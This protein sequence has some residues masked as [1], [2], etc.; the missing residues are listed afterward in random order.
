MR[1]PSNIL[2]YSSIFFDLQHIYRR[3]KKDKRERIRKQKKQLFFDLPHSPWSLMGVTAPF[4][5]QST[6]SGRSS[7][8]TFA[9]LNPVV[10]GPLFPAGLKPVRAALNSSSVRSANWLASSQNLWFP[11]LTD[12]MNATLALK[13]SY[14]RAFSAASLYTRPYLAIHCSCLSTMDWAARSRA[15]RAWIAQAPARTA[16]IRR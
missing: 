9:Y 14:R 12:S 6:E 11:A 3:L 15:A 4:A 16:K 13:I 1:T 2:K 5:L 10:D 7:M 8:L